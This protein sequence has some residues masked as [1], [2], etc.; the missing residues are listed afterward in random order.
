MRDDNLRSSHLNNWSS[1]SLK[2]GVAISLILVIIGLI[3]IGTTGA[4]GV[5]PIVPL[6]QLPQEILALNAIAIITTG[7]LILLLTPILQV[8]IAIVTFSRDRDRLY[9]SI[10]LILLCILVSSLLLALM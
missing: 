8:V 5:E 2:L 10:S 6:N 9:L 4:K 3:L 1:L 7:I